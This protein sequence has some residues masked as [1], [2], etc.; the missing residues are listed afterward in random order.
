MPDRLPEL[1]QLLR[2]MNDAEVAKAWARTKRA[3]G[4]PIQVFGLA[5]VVGSVREAAS[6]KQYRDNQ[7]LV[8]IKVL[9]A[10]G[11]LTQTLPGDHTA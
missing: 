7:V 9:E 2:D 6:H 10:A 5:D 8:T 4:G 3:G 1:D 11:M